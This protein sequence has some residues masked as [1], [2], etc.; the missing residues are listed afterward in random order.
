MQDILERVIFDSSVHDLRKNIAKKI[1][2]YLGDRISKDE[3]IVIHELSGINYPTEF[4]NETSVDNENAW[5]AKQRKKIELL[6]A[7]F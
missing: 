7:G 1:C 3:I 2:E 6:S 5:A 4:V